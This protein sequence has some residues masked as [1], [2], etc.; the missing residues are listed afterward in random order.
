MIMTEE[1]FESTNNIFMERQHLYNRVLLF[2]ILECFLWLKK[3]LV[4]PLLI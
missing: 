2:C 3:E 1:I 4:E